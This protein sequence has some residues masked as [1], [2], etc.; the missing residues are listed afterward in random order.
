MKLPLFILLHLAF[1]MVDGLLTLT[2]LTVL[3]GSILVARLFGVIAGYIFLAVA[4]HH[5]AR[6]HTT[7]KTL[8][9]VISLISACVSFGLF[10]LILTR[11]PIIQWP[12]AFAAGS[13]AA[14]AL[15]ALGYIRATRVAGKSL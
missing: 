5:V 7:G 10:A 4:I 8:A 3:P 1:I 9:I 11:N 14:L 13:I 2:M 15:A 6:M 12:V